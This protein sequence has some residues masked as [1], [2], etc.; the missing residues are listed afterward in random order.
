MKNNKLNVGVGSPKTG[1]PPRTWRFW[2][3]ATFLLAFSSIFAQTDRIPV[4]DG[5]FSNG[6]S[7]AANNWSVSNGATPNHQWLVSSAH[8]LGAPFAGNAA[9]VSDNG[10][11]YNYTPANNSNIFFWRDV[12]VPAGESIMNLTFNW[13]LQGESSWDLWQVFVGPTSITPVGNNTHPGSGTTNVPAPITGATYVGNGSLLAGIQTFSGSIPASFAGTTFRVFFSWKNETGGS[14]PPAAIDNIRLT[15]ALPANFTATAQGGLWNDP[16]TW[17][18]GVVPAAGN[19]ITI[20]AGSTVIVN[21]VLSY[22]DL[23]V[24]G[25]LFWNGTFATTLTGNFVVNAGARVNMLSTGGAGQQINIAGNMTNDGLIDAYFGTLF[26]NGAGNSQLSGSGNFQSVGGRG[27]V[28]NLFTQNN[29]TFTLNQTQNITVT[30]QLSNT[31]NNFISNGKIR[32]DNAVDYLVNRPLVISLTAMGSGYTTAPVVLGQ[33]VSPWVASG[34][35]AAGTRYYNGTNV[36]LCTTAGTFG[37]SAPAN[38][39]PATEGN[40]TATVLWVGNLGNIGNAFQ[41]TAVTAG[42]QYYCGNNLYI[43]TVA[44]TPSATA[45]PVHVSGTAVSGTATFAYVGTVAKVSLNYNGTTQTVRSLNIVSEG[46]GYQSSPAIVITNTG[47]GTGATAATLW[48]AATVGTAN[49]TATKA[50]ASIFTGAVDTRHS[51]GIGTQAGNGVYSATPGGAAGWY[52]TVP[53]VG[54]TL[55]PL[56]NLVSAQGSGYTSAPT[57]VVTGGTLVSGVNPL[58]SAFQVNVADGRV[59][60]LY[61]LTPGTTAIYSVPPTITVTGG[62]GSGATFNWSTFLPTA[63]VTLS[64]G[65]SGFVTGITI[66]NNGIG[67]VTAPTMGFRAAVAGEVAATAPTCRLQQLNIQWGFFT[68]QTTNPNNNSVVALLPS[69]RRINGFVVSS[70]AQTFNSNVTATALAPL[71]TFA[72]IIDMG[73]SNI[74]RFSHPDYLGTAGTVSAY[75]A[76]GSV[77]LSLRGGIVSATRTFP[78]GGGTGATA[79]FV[80]TTGSSVV[81]TTGYT[82]TGVRVIRTALPSGTVSSGGNLTGIRGVKVDLQGTGVL[83]NLNP[84]T[85]TMQMNYNIL[86]N[87]ISNNQSLFLAEATALTG[88]WTA[89]S[90]A[91]LAGALAS[92]GNRVTATI[93]PGPYTN[94]TSM[95]FAWVNNGFT[96]PPPLVYNVTR[97]T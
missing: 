85:R 75:V 14:Q 53:T 8:G 4:S 31:A 69:N 36:Y 2:L 11:A 33:A 21:Q 16:A 12:T 37:A 52:N 78:I 30:S 62:G 79:Q 73:G 93:A 58:P 51:D 72:G 68:P 32:V 90:A 22:R 41:V 17:V 7:F 80:H 48:S 59:I 46:S 44:G 70:G 6:A 87:L 55:P 19:D 67:Y 3:V 76:N 1:S 94:N 10:T 96:P 20:P 83:T 5:A 64:N 43:C 95:F 57:V 25:N 47:A 54:F 29:G 77:E 9:F 23:T 13:N 86:D 66:N 65:T 92:T 84:T 74:L 34:A 15:S 91:G 56:V 81:T 89:R 18:G 39:A 82:Y 50:T 97:S 45:P 49:S 61:C 27:I 42:I 26:F 60:S 38:T 63:T 35:A 40:G 28:R 88:P 71:G 24:N